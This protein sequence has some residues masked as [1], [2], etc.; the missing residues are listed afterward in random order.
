MGGKRPNM[1]KAI[2]EAGA[3]RGTVGKPPVASAKDRATNQVAAEVVPSTTPSD[4]CRAWP[5]DDFVN[6]PG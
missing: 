4:R 3:G 6:V 2:A 5:C 1:S